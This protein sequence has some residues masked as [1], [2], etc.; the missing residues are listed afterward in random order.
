MSLFDDLPEPS[1]ESNDLQKPEILVGDSSWNELE[2][3][4]KLTPYLCSVVARKGERPEMQDSHIVIDNL[5]EL[6]YRGVSNEIARVCYFAIFDGH[7]G[8]KAA[9]FACKRLHQHIA[10]RFPRGGM[11]QVEKDIKRVL[12]DSY[13]KTDEEF[14]REACQQRPHWRDGSTSAT[15]LLVNNTLYIANLGDSKVVLARLVESP[16]ESNNVDVN[17]SNTLSNP[18]L[19]AI[20]LTKDHNPMDYEE[21]QRIQATGASVQNGRVNNVLE[22]SRSFG[23]YQFKKQGVTCIPDVKKCQLTDNDQFLLIACDGLWKSFPPN[24]AVHLT[25][26]LLMQEIKKYENEH[27]ESQNGQCTDYSQILCQRHLDSVCTHL[28]SE[29]VLRMSGDNVTCIL[30]VFPTMFVKKHH[31]TDLPGHLSISHEE[32]SLEPRSKLP[33]I[34]K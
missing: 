26:E 18:K 20:C 23:D 3:V 22:V 31:S 28:V 4:V 14:L 29:A 12:Y 17:S 24:E 5:V 15:I 25:H 7:G 11:Q 32:D 1:V 8:A 10:M 16:S 13:K 21:R 27:R 6:M 34:E 9:N 2:S 30:L 33:R 19:S